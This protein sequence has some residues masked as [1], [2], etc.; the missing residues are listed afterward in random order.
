[1]GEVRLSPIP[2]FQHERTSALSLQHHSNKVSPSDN[3]NEPKQQ[4]RGVLIP[5]DIMT[6]LQDGM[7]NPTECLLLAV[8]D[9]FV[10]ARG[11]GCWASNTT[12]G[13]TLGGLSRKHVS[14]M[15]AKLIK[16]GL[17]IR[18][19]WKYTD[20]GKSVRVIETIWSR[21][22]IKGMGEGVRKDP[23]GGVRI[24]PDSP[25][26]A[27]PP[28]GNFQNKQSIDDITYCRHD[29]TASGDDAKPIKSNGKPTKVKA[30]GDSQTSGQARSSNGSTKGEERSRVVGDVNP[31]P[32]E[33]GNGKRHARGQARS[34]SNKINGFP[35]GEG[36][37]VRA[38][39][40]VTEFGN[41]MAILLRD[42]LMAKN[43][44]MRPVSVE[45]WSISLREMRTLLMDSRKLTRQEA[46]GSIEDLI[47]DHVK[48]IRDD[49]QP[50]AYSADTF[51]KKY[52][53]I[54]RARDRRSRK[55]KPIK[56]IKNDNGSVKRIYPDDPEY[57][58]Y[59][60]DE[61]THSVK[62]IAID[63]ATGRVMSRD[64]FTDD[65]DY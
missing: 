7:I 64:E 13:N 58:Q 30:R 9:S 65:E 37:P 21:I 61:D 39:V 59:L 1:M 4:C 47:N 18:K 32:K 26:T 2:K 38:S 20:D 25:E 42:G 11:L 6:C 50:E 43:K 48:H 63:A 41:R 52:E 29:A 45:K 28:S 34:H 56:T 10:N 19:G 12:L 55:R 24:N 27:V 53:S 17:I 22:E 15:I 31:E 40:D 35:V 54:E 36:K 62:I 8:V 44:I 16:I 3:T 5:P 51:C 57:D 23:E 14:D 49:Y 33:E 60:P 46:E